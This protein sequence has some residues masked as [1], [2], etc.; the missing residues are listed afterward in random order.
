MGKEHDREYNT[1]LNQIEFFKGLGLGAKESMVQLFTGLNRQD[2]IQKELYSQQI[3]PARAV[4]DLLASSERGRAMWKKVTGKELPARTL[5]K[6]QIWD[7]ALQATIGIPAEAVARALNIGDKPQRFA[8]ER[9]QAAT[10]AKNLGL[11]D[12]DYKYFLAFPKEEA[13]RAYKAK[14]LSAAEAEKKAQYIA[15][16]IVKEGERS[17]F[18][19]DNFL[20]K[21]LSEAFGSFT[22][23][24]DSGLSNFLKATTVSP[25]VKIPAN[26]FWSGYN[27]VNPEVALLQ[28]FIYA[29]KAASKKKSGKTAFP[30]DRDNSS[31]EKD[32]REAR[33]WMAHA[34]TG[35]ALRGL[36][37]ALVGNG[38]YNPAN[39][40]DETKKEREGEGAYVQ[41][42]TINVTK[43]NAWLRGEDPSKVKGGLLVQN[44]WFGVMG[45]IGN[46]I[47]RKYYDM[48][49]EQRANQD[50]FSN[51]LFGGLEVDALKEFEQGVFSNTSSMLSA[52]NGNQLD[53][54]RWGVGVLN[55]LANTFHPAALAQTSK[56]DLD[57]VA[58]A[59]ADTFGKQLENSM[60][61]RSSMLRNLL[62]KYPPAKVNI[63]GE[64]MM[65]DKSYANRL[66]GFTNANKDA[67]AMPIFEDAKRTGDIGYFP[68]AVPTILN[69][70]KLTADQYTSLST[71][72]G[73]ERKRLIAPYI[74]DA[75]EIDGYNTKYSQL[76]DDKRKKVLERF[77]EIGR[78][79]G[80][81]KFYT[82]FPDLKPKDEE[83]DYL[84][85]AQRSLFLELTE[86]LKAKDW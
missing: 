63:W 35:V 54:R 83:P 46:T 28:S 64:P 57:Y 68:P 3:R 52:L 49:P 9:S 21:L 51:T 17:T 50:G 23:K 58:S 81:M 30:F 34:V 24:K 37:I 36:V 72:V 60:L 1:A 7:K 82:D 76:P 47:A 80:L 45:T 33:Y 61:Q 15:D 2:Y 75:A 69:D 38:I 78:L 65:K 32:M 26:A 55:M 22:G 11:K 56:A 14:G 67:F 41:N 19:Q 29:G 25:F 71:Y 8:A 62:N 20:N 4:R 31:A 86:L 42:G 70:K 44:K 13:F 39:T 18:Q 66:F 84:E 79:N 59:N 74:N 77:Y 40:G 85:Q 10:F 6:Q 27:L 48:T 43:L 16:T 5:T 73:Q 12:L 53:S